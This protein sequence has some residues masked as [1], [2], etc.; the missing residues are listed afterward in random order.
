MAKY[1]RFNHEYKY[2]KK[3]LRIKA[4]EKREKNFGVA[5]L[6]LSSPEKA[7]DLILRFNDIKRQMK[8]M[9]PETYKEMSIFVRYL[10]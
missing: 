9:D 6:V 8:K 1:H 10:I 4:A 5:F 7:Q 3:R 2:L